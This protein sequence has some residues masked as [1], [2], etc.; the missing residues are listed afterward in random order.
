VPD[1]TLVPSHLCG[2]TDSRWFRAGVPGV[3]AYGFCPFL[4]EDS[5]SMGGREH[6]KDERVAT[7]DLPFQALFYQ[8]LVADLLG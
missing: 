5:A 2:F 1:A 3:V 4:A 6:A 8:R 7:S